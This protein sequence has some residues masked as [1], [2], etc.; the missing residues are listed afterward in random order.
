MF[1]DVKGREI[2]VG[3]TVQRVSAYSYG[4]LHVGACGIVTRLQSSGTLE[5]NN[6]NFYFHYTRNYVVVAKGGK[7][8]KKTGFGSFIQRIE[9]EV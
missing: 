5:L 6:I 7:K 3:D 4:G 8:R 9:N 2:E 1:R